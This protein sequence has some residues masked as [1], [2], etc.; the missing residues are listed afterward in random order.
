MILKGTKE[1]KTIPFAIIRRCQLSV[2]RNP[3]IPKSH[4]FLNETARETGKSQSAS[5]RLA[6][7]FQTKTDCFQKKAVEIWFILELRF[8]HLEGFFSIFLVCVFSSWLFFSISDS[9]FWR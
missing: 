7:V 8:G 2:W 9:I 6:H 1:K 4:H 3:E 5:R